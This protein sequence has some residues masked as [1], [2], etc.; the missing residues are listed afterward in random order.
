[1]ERFENRFK[2]FPISLPL[3]KKEAMK[4]LQN[5]DAEK[6]GII[7]DNLHVSNTQE[8]INRKAYYKTLA[9]SALEAIRRRDV[10]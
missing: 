4:F 9:Y 5:K 3:V 6:F 8:A 7:C 2:T 10:A 1:M